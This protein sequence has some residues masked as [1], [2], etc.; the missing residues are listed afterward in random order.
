M[1]S[2]CVCVVTQNYCIF[3][4]ECECYTICV[5]DAVSF[6][7]FMDTVATEIPSKW[8]RIGVAVGMSQS[9]ID[10][11]DNYRH[12]KSFDC[13]CV[14]FKHWQQTGPR[15]SLCCVLELLERGHWLNAFRKHLCDILVMKP[16]VLII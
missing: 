1:Y 8:K 5:G 6:I 15:S 9:Q 2:V 4:S 16:A 3:N 13:F 14:A 11:V 12:G 10:E 7:Q